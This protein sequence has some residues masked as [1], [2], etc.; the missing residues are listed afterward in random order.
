MTGVS[1]VVPVRNGAATIGDT[2]SSIFAQA[3]GRPMEVIV[4]D[5]RSAD[6]SRAIVAAHAAGQPVVAIDGGGRGAAAAI[7]QGL[8][9]ARF[10][11]VCQVDQDV[12]LRAGWMRALVDALGDDP[13]VGAAQGYYETD[14]RAGVCARVMGLDLEA[15][16][17]AI[18]GVE[19]DHVCTGNSAYRVEALRRIGGFDE[20]LGYGYDNDA[21]Y[22]LRAAGYRLVLCRS[23]RSLHR[24]RDGFVGYLTQQYG[25][26]YGRL[27]LV[28]KHPN[29]AGG[30]RVSPWAMMA[31]PL[32]AL[33][34]VA[35]LAVAAGFAVA[36]ASPTWPR[37]I[38][39]ALVAL[40]AAERLVA[41]IRAA[42]RFRQWTPVLFPVLHL[43]RD[44]AWVAATI[45]WAVRRLH[46][47]ASA[48]SDSMQPRPA[49]PPERS[50]R[51]RFARR[52]AGAPERVMA[53]IPAHNEREN[54]PAVV[55]DV[56]SR[57]PDLD[58]LVVDDGSTDGTA[59]LLDELD[60]HWLRFPER[61]GIGSAVRAGLRYASHLGYDAAVRLD[62]DGQHGGDEI[63]ALLA[64]IGD[65]AA[66]VVIGSRYHPDAGTLLVAP[67]AS[68]AL[69][70]CLSAIAGTR[71]TD[72]T[73][74]FYA[75]G[76]NALRLLAEHHPTGYPEP[77]LRLFLSRN[78]LDALEVPVRA[79]SRLAG[80][81][82]LT[83]GRVTTAGARVALAMILV[84]LRPPVRRGAGK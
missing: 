60:V 16:Y 54:L 71:I 37:S 44:L 83:A 70:A 9:A 11:I 22:R 40:L 28:A 39:G 13:A 25:F 6:E 35:T 18:D 34:G 64:P 63:D 36:G 8:R 38:G 51:A 20:A 3:D 58:I 31:H 80:R 21:S 7:N 59:W 68:R 67:L 17:A 84:P 74:G 62:G 53:I 79:R 24:W 73:S 55:A 32:L 33:V 52:A 29:R 49:P 69:A 23:A 42:R 26:G 5:D 77:E 41:G 82:S 2:L 57:R 81:T 12:V 47:R 27:D 15:R 1:V 56:R 43:A 19:T 78:G 65:G 30:D 66:D 4:V 46:G 14:P 76:P 72:P 10:P 61:L 75:V 50:R 48:P 45:A